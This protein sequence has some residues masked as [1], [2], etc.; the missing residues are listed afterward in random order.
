MTGS[1]MIGSVAWGPGLACP[2]TLSLLLHTGAELTHKQ[3]TS[4]ISVSNWNGVAYS[5]LMQILTDPIARQDIAIGQ[6]GLEG[7]ID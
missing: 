3:S 7:P 6:T 5:F 4:D 1:E 2:S